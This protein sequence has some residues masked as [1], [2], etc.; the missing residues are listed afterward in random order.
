M[1]L[2]ERALDFKVKNS[3]AF[4]VSSKQ[5]KPL[6]LPCRISQL[7]IVLGYAYNYAKTA[8]RIF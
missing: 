7:E 8:L 4:E 6:F 3:G 5:S 1:G 2:R